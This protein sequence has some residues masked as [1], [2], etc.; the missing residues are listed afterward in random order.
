MPGMHESS[1]KKK[2]KEKKK[3]TWNTSLLEKEWQDSFQ[4][5]HLFRGYAESKILELQYLTGEPLFPRWIRVQG[6]RGQGQPRAQAHSQPWPSTY[7]TILCPDYS[8]RLEK[9]LSAVV[10]QHKHYPNRLISYWKCNN[11]KKR[12]W[13]I[14]WKAKTKAEF[15][16]ESGA[17]QATNTNFTAQITAISERTL[18]KCCHQL[19]QMALST[20]QSTTRQS[21]CSSS[22][23][24][25]H[26]STELSCL[27]S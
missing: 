2:Q 18:A 9:L 16:S 15:T 13:K 6:E 7:K 23:E 10:R 19:Q 20:T 4:T 27:N 25:Q 17:Q 26:W 24:K 21:D 12:N 1:Q 11:S 5:A 22:N 3:A 8:R 14:T